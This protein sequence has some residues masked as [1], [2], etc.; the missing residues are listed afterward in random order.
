MNRE[1]RAALAQATLNILDQGRYHTPLGREVTLNPQQ[2]TALAG[3][4]LFR[5]TDFP[6]EIQIQPEARKYS[7]N[8]TVTNET[9][10]EAARRLVLANP[11]SDVLALNFASA[12]HPGGGFLSG[13]QAQE[14]SLARSSGLYPCLV[15]MKEMYEFNQRCGT[16]LYSDFMI[17]SPQVPVFRNDDGALLEEPYL[18][19]FVTAP[20][21]NAGAVKR[22]ESRNISRILPVMTERARKLLWLAWEKGHTDLVLGAWGCGVFGNEP[23]DIARIFAGLL[24]SNGMFESVFRQIVFAVYDRSEEKAGW[25]AFAGSF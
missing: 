3:T 10:L 7:T 24:T 15:Q 8:L 1:R 14:E 9:T 12:K 21:V 17:H 11:K 23:R 16:C 18:V 5:P 25:K 19:S 20:A 2:E 22:N 4:K 6:K 13:S